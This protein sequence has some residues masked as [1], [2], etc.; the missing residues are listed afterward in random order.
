[1]SPQNSAP[2]GVLLAFAGSVTGVLD[3][4]SAPSRVSGS[5]S[6]D[7]DFNVTA[8]QVSPAAIC[9]ADASASFTTPSA[10]PEGH[11]LL[12]AQFA[13]TTYTWSCFKATETGWTQPEES[14][15]AP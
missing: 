1:L 14:F 4:L 11:Q 10:P 9:P 8:P 6:T 3:P 2:S 7:P 13:P 12:S 15:T 5:C